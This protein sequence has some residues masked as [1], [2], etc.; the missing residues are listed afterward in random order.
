MVFFCHSICWRLLWLRRWHKCTVLWQILIQYQ[1]KKW[2]LSA[3][4]ECKSCA[5]HHPV[6]DS[7][8]QASSF[9]SFSFR[10]LNLSQ[11]WNCGLTKWL[12][13]LKVPRW[14]VQAPFL[15]QGKRPF[16]FSCL[17][18]PALVGWVVQDCTVMVRFCYPCCRLGLYLA[19]FAAAGSVLEQLV[20]GTHFIFF[21]LHQ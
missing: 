21:L 15:P 17:I 3:A 6:Q 20:H 12:A 1:C 14:V 13:A 9:L 5:W 7:Q 10:V 2:L 18:D 16:Y 11:T 4:S 8:K 19:H